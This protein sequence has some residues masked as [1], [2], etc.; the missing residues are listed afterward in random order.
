MLEFLADIYL[1]EENGGAMKGDGWSGMMPSLNMDGQFVMSKVLADKPLKKGEW[2]E[3]IIQLPYGNE[4]EYIKNTIKEGYEFK[5][6]F[7]VK[8]LGEG[9]VKSL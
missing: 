5:L 9:R 1:Y 2:H 7:G 4:F 3:V 6:N 8:V